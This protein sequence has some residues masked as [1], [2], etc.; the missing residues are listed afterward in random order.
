MATPAICYQIT[1]IDPHAHL[2]EVRLTVQHPDPAGP[3]FSL[4]AWIPGSYMIREFSK[5]IVALSAESAGRKTPLTQLDKHT[6]QARPNLTAPIT[7]TALIHAWD[8]SVRGAHLDATHGFFNPTSLCLCVQGSEHLPC[9]VEL[10][11]PQGAAYKNWRVATT[12]PQA[13]GMKGAAKRHGFGRYRAADYDSLIDHPVEMGEFSRTQFSACGVVHEVAIT[14]RHDCDLKRL[15]DDLQKICQWHIQLFGEPA[16]F[17]R[18][19]FLVT[20]VGE[21]YGG[22]EHRDSTALLCSRDDLPHA[23]MGEMS[24]A[25]RG[26]LGLCSH[27]YF[28]AWNVKRIKPAAF[29]PYDLTQE[30]YTT[31][32]WAFEGFTSYYD[33]LALVRSG[34]ITEREYLDILQKSITQLART[35]GRTRQSV[36]QSSFNAWTKYYRQDENSPNAIVSYYLKGS[37]I[38]LALD[39]LLRDHTQGRVSLDHV[40]VALWQQFGQTGQGVGEES[41]REIAESLSGADL[42]AFFAKAVLGVDELPLDKVLHPMGVSLEWRAEKSQPVAGLKF[43]AGAEARIQYVFADG[44]AH[45]AGLSAGD[46]IIAMDGLKVNADTFQKRCTRHKPGDTLQVHAFRRDQLMS[47]KLTLAKP[48]KDQCILTVN[49]KASARAKKLRT[50]WLVD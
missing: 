4:P 17:D 3:R 49:P 9:V 26:F 14:G 16:P 29:I 46:V 30:N 28:H 32:L 5:N 21:G 48:P 44:P 45:Q 20:A 23:G 13:R 38:A 50:A 43:A 18:Y 22:L 12:L 15:T 34:L 42:K 2:F 7:V 47:F 40:M 1:P 37:L 33:D 25:Y 31:L 35:P 36:A 10:R 8:L 19:L 24:E 41:I 6:W 11:P 27:E 39:C